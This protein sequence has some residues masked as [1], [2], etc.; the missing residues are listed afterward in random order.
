MGRLKYSV[1]IVL[2]QIIVQMDRI[3]YIYLMG[4]CRICRFFT[5]NKYTYPTSKSDK[6]I[7]FPIRNTNFDILFVKR[8]VFN[9][10][11][12]T[13]IREVEEK[14]PLSN[15]YFKPQAVLLSY[16]KLL[17][18]NLQENSQNIPF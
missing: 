12:I 18:K 4:R 9:E 13:N 11:R 10:Y 17:R 16:T 1:G 3:I 8:R 15:R 7:I 14:N 5:L 2:V 6:Y